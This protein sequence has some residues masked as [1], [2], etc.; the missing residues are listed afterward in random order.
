[1]M[2]TQLYRR[3]IAEVVRISAGW[4]FTDQETILLL[5][6]YLAPGETQQTR[7]RYIGNGHSKDVEDRIELVRRL[8]A[9]VAKIKPRAER[10]RRW[11]DLPRPDLGGRNVKD[12]IL[13]GHLSD[14][15]GAVV[16]TEKL[17]E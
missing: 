5:G 13:T 11:L 14:L 15:A 6:H 2:S 4:H 8:K 1:M 3:G 7:M 16:F 10:Q 9:A 17:V 12:L